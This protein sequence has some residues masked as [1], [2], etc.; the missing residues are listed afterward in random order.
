MRPSGL[1]AQGV[2]WAQGVIRAQGVMGE[3]RGRVRGGKLRNEFS[4][5]CVTCVF[6]PCAHAR[7]AAVSCCPLVPPIS[8]VSPS[9]SWRSSAPPSPRRCAEGCRRCT[10]QHTAAQ[11]EACCPRTGDPDARGP[12]QDH[13]LVSHPPVTARAVCGGG[14]QAAPPG[15]V[16]TRDVAQEAAATG[17]VRRERCAKRAP[18]EPLHPVP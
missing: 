5:G 13:R 18:P 4:S 11:R 3:G 12:A 16:P 7:D 10:P 1:R 8:S 6:C 14:T 17:R 15:R 9:D 2:I